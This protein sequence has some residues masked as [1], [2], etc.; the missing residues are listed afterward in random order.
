M[1]CI[2]RVLWLDSMRIYTTKPVCLAIVQYFHNGQHIDFPQADKKLSV[3]HQ[4]KVHLSHLMA[5]G[6]E[7]N[8]IPEVDSAK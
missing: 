2:K 8:A 7:L 6:R 5:I 3:P 4:R 1:S